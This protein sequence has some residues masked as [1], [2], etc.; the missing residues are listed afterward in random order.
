ME[1]STKAKR[2]GDMIRE[3]HEDWD[4][5]RRGEPEGVNKPIKVAPILLSRL[6][7]VGH[8]TM[9]MPMSSEVGGDRVPNPSKE[10]RNGPEACQ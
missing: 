6:G 9:P 1:V 7:G 4:G 10:P 2:N 8:T 3:R 5:M